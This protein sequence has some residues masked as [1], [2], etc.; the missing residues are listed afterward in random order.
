MKFCKDCKHFSDVGS[1]CA[2]GKKVSGQH[3]VHGYNEYS[4]KVLEY[5][6]AERDS[7]LPWHCGKNGRHFEE[8]E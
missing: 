5:A 2:R 3:P 1:Y 8:K 6:W 4:Y 7:W